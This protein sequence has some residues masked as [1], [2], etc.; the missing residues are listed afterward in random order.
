MKDALSRR[1]APSAKR[2]QLR[3]A[4]ND[5]ATALVQ[6][7][8]TV[9]A[10]AFRREVEARGGMIRSWL[11]PA[12]VVSVEFPA[13]ALSELADLPGVVYVE[14]AQAYRP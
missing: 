12:N 8:S 5:R 2:L 1:L 9:D 11:R 14:A 13:R 7:A 6:V 10:E 3:S 4:E